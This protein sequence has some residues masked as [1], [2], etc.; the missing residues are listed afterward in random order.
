MS[1]RMKEQIPAGKRSHPSHLE[2]SELNTIQKI[3]LKELRLFSAKQFLNIRN[4]Y[5]M[6]LPSGGKLLLLR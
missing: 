4:L 5:E 6:F 3:G 2:N 1:S